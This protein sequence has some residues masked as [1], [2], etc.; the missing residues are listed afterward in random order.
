VF[1]LTPRLADCALGCTSE[2]ITAA[3]CGGE[4]WAGGVE[5]ERCPSDD[6]LSWPCL[7]VLVLVILCSLVE[8]VEDGFETGPMGCKGIDKIAPLFRSSTQVV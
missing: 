2:G 3:I 1:G 8:L 5:G 4:A 6:I 7:G